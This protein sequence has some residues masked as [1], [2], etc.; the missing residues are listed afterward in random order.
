MTTVIHS[1]VENVAHYLKF[2]ESQ[3]SKDRLIDELTE[4]ICYY[5]SNI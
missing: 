5:A 3:I 1:A 2:L 4:M